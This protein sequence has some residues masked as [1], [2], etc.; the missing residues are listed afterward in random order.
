MTQEMSSSSLDSS[1]NLT[2]SKRANKENLAKSVES[3]IMSLKNH[4]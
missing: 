1:Q 2:P 3:M 4:L